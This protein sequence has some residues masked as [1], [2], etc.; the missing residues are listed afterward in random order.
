ML[1]SM[2]ACGDKEGSSQSGESSSGSD[3]TSVKSLAEELG[4]GYISTYNDLPGDFDSISTLT[5]ANGRYYFTTY[6]YDYTTYESTTTLMSMNTDCTDIQEI[7]TP[8]FDD[9]IYR[10]YNNFQ[11][12]SDGNLWLMIYEYYF[13]EDSGEIIDDDFAVPADEEVYEDV[14][15]ATDDAV[16]TEDTLVANEMAT[17]VAAV[18]T[19]EAAATDDSDIGTIERYML[20]KCDA[21]GNILDSTNLSDLK[22]DDQNYIWFNSMVLDADNNLYLTG[23]STI[24]VLNSDLELQFTIEAENWV[25]SI[26]PTSDGDVVCLYWGD[27][28]YC[29]NTIDLESKSLGES[30]SIPN[31][32]NMYSIIA[33]GNTGYDL[34]THDGNV[35]YGYKI[36]DNSLTP[37]LNWLECDINGSNAYNMCAVSDTEFAMLTYDD[38][39]GSTVVVT[40]NQVPYSELPVRQ[41]ITFAYT[42]YLSYNTRSAILSFNRRNSTY[43]VTTV[44]YSQYNT[45]TDPEQGATRLANDILAGKVPDLVDASSF[46]IASYAEKGVFLDLYTLI[47][48]DSELDR[49]FFVDGVLENLE[50]NGKLYTMATS[51]YLES[52]LGLTEVVGDHAGWTFDDMMAA[53]NTLDDDAEI[54][55]YMT[56]SSFLN[57]CIRAG[58]DNYINWETGQCN[59]A[60]EDFIKLLE[61]ASAFPEEVDYSSYDDGVYVSDPS[62]LYQ[63]K[64][65]MC[66][67][68]LSS[69][70]DLDWYRAY[71]RGKDYTIVGYPCSTE[72]GHM[73]YWSDEMAMSATSSVTEGAWEFIKY[74]LSD[75]YQT[76]SIWNFPINNNVFQ[77]KKQ[78]AM[79]P[80]YYL[81]EDGNKV[82][83]EN[84]WT[85]DDGTEYVL[86]PMTEAEI[87]K[88]MDAISNGSSSYKYDETISDIISEETAYFFDG[89]KTAQQVAE[90]IQ[91][92]VQTYIMESM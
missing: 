72:N 21:Q 84:N 87:Q 54:M 27:S 29:I 67:V 47:D 37:I 52:I 20:Y 88:I 18:A 58:Y 46:D 73:I 28:G 55:R 82:E 62:L 2:A 45:D 68:Y 19:L 33:A 65:L 61:V 6:T 76:N 56:Q 71:L 51:F 11:I 48:S 70:S 42:S 7:P 86:S 22:S 91:N 89:S 50:T 24:Y 32:Y 5:F 9:P 77:Q 12:D 79:E 83:Y 8:Q 49:N 75:E 31:G 44:D 34:L 80:N 39:I 43:R 74:F 25:E 26:V 90:L 15:E 16:E 60:G 1:L 38:A 78:E 3:N 4:Y 64:I 13:P 41:T 81:D 40:I 14:A 23:D 57:Y 35:L 66:D 30:I 63:G 53:Y 92:R 85:L 10:S 59:F 36:D 17:A 69:F